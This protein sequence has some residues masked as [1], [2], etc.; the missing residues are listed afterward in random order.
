MIN[1]LFECGADIHATEKLFGQCPHF[2]AKTVEVLN[3]LIERGANLECEDTDN[4]RALHIYSSREHR[5]P[6]IKRC[7]ELGVIHNI[8]E[9]SI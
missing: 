1:W 9:H 4:Y 5:Y 7:M 2:F 6:I 3:L 8:R